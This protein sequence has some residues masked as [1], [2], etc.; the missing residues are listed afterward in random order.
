MVQTKPSPNQPT[1]VRHHETL[2][3]DDWS[4]SGRRWREGGD[5][6]CS[7]AGHGRYSQGA[8]REEIGDEA[9]RQGH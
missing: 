4:G 1:D 6:G 3:L 7:L 5:S 8:A 2:R 9:R